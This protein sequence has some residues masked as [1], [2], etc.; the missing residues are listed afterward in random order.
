VESF[1]LRRSILR[2]DSDGDRQQATM[3]LISRHAVVE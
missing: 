3:V 1:E 2:D